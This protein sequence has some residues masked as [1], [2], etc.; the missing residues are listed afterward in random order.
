[1]TRLQLRAIFALAGVAAVFGLSGAKKAEAAQNARVTVPQSV[2]YKDATPQ[3]EV[4]ATV[5]QDQVLRVSDTPR[6][7]WYRVLVPG[8]RVAGW[9]HEQDV[10]PMVGAEP[11]RARRAEDAPAPSRRAVAVFKPWYLYGFGQMHYIQPLQSTGITPEPTA[12]MAPSFGA[13]LGRRLTEQFSLAAHLESYK[14]TRTDATAYR[15]KGT[16]VGVVGEY[17][18]SDNGRW[19]FGGGIGL[20]ASIGTTAGAAVGAVQALSASFTAPFILL[21]LIGRHAFSDS[22]YGVA[23]LGYRSISKSSVPLTATTA[24]DVNLQSPYLGLGLQLAF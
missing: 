6:G 19:S 1:M 17:R 7:G 22:F 4:L 9:I 5:S 16:V 18:F 10:M 15:V 13:E 11:P 12:F 23:E 14:F 24:I 21:R 20:G 8:Q 3:S 2:I